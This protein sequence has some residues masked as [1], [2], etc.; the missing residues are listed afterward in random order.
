MDSVYRRSIGA[1]TLVEILMVIAIIGILAAIVIPEFQEHSQQAKESAA[2][3][4]LRL[5]RNVIELY[6]AQHKGVP[7]GYPNGDIT[8]TPSV[9]ILMLQL[10]KATNSDG[11]ITSVGT[12]GS[13]GPYLST[14]PEN[15]LNGRI[16]I[17]VTI[18][19]LP[20]E[21]TDTTGWIY[22]P[23]TKTIKLNA[24]GKDS[25]GVRYYDY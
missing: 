7:P 21:A 3:E 5:L 8:K 14:L 17:M 20:A 6:A 25:Q 10:M 22:K 1:F 12:A 15:P 9:T 16:T 24:P 19:T 2:K 4:N 18:N 23:L 11:A 13:L